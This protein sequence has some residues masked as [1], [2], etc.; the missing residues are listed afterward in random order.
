MSNFENKIKVTDLRIGNVVQGNK[1]NIILVEN[2]VESGINIDW[3]WQEPK[4]KIRDLNPIPLT[5]DWLSKLGFEFEDRG[6]DVFD[7]I[8]SKDDFEIWEHS[9]GFC[10]N[11]HKGGDINH[12]HE[13]QNMYFVLMGEELEVKI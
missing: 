5:E 10:H 7:Q 4:Y 11:Y 1:G 9:E 8:W 13:L 12:L 3:D 6:E 2:I